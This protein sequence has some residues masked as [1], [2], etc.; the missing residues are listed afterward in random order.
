ML[1]RLKESK[2]S[3]GKRMSKGLSKIDTDKIM[4]GKQKKVIA[5]NW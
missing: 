4:R 5:D 3:D 1:R 2:K